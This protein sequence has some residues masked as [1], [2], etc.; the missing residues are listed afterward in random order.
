M[1]SV[2]VPAHNEEAVIGR[3]LTALLEGARPGELEAIVACNGCSDR[4][5]ERARSFGPPVRVI[6]IEQAS[7]T[8]AI[9]AAER[10]VTAFPRLYVDADV[11]L[12]LRGVRAVAAA[13]GSGVLASPVAETDLGPASPAV[14][15][16]YAIWLSLPY[17]QVMVGTGVYALSE[18]G[19]ARFGEFPPVIADDGFVRSLFR[20]EDRIAVP[21]AI[22]RVV[23]PRTLR[24]LVRVAT[25]VRQGIYQLRTRQPD[26]R[27]T[28][29]KN[30][31]SILQ[32]LPKSFALPWQMMVYLS[33]N[34]VV[35]IRARWARM[36]GY[37]RQW[38]RDD[39]ARV[40]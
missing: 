9:N 25:R 36:Y 38:Y 8:A 35:R 16:F 26:G 11:E 1:I 29:Q 24:D 4:T 32:S 23:A 12:Q 30:I 21:E 19:R 14:R 39:A 10:L 40:F 20:P 2:I 6:E 27:V 17:N 31:L 5:A 28:D 33:V 7:K 34:F 15:A 37:E 18:E 13:L 22:V 3:C